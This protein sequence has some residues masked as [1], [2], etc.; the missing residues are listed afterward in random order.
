MQD[1]VKLWN[2]TTTRLKD[3]QN[4]KKWIDDFILKKKKKGMLQKRE[5][6]KNNI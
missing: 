4:A 6:R 2:P 3:L 1:P 5:K